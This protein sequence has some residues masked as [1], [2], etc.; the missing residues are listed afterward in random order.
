MA[1]DATPNGDVLLAMSQF[2]ESVIQSKPVAG[3]AL[4][5][6]LG[7]DLLKPGAKQEDV[8]GEPTRAGIDPGSQAQPAQQDP[9]TAEAERARSGPW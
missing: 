3:S 2:P 9:L 7:H 8:G 6:L 1:S 4:G 5:Q